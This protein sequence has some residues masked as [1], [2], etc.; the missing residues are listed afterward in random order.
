M[1]YILKIFSILIFTK[2]LS[3]SSFA[4]LNLSGYQEFFAG[5]SDQS[6]REGLDQSTNTGNS[7]AGLSNGTYT[8]LV[9]T[10]TAKLD[11][12]IDV[13]GVYSI[14]KDDKGGDGDVLGVSTN[15]K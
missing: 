6:I 2:F 3:F 7:Q 9:A 8:R 4:E 10:A 15:V 5:S 12:G 13:V 1:K 11:N 14:M